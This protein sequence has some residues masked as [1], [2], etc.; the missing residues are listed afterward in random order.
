MLQSAG[1]HAT[2]DTNGTTAAA[3]PSYSFA[4]NSSLGKSLYVPLVASALYWKI[5]GAAFMKSFGAVPFVIMITWKSL[6]FSHSNFQGVQ[7]QLSWR[8]VMFY[9]PFISWFHLPIVAY[10]YIMLTLTFMTYIYISSI[11]YILSTYKITVIWCN[12]CTASTVALLIYFENGRRGRWEGIWNGRGREAMCRPMWSRKVG[13]SSQKVG[14]NRWSSQ[15]WLL[16]DRSVICAVTPGPYVT[17]SLMPLCP[18]C[19]GEGNKQSALSTPKSA[20][21]AVTF[22]LPAI[23]SQPDGTGAAG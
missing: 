17:V 9:L 10:N 3:L 7:S 16:Y 21:T 14:L 11:S 1:P 22:S 18:C 2:P 23:P 4:V 19:A 12:F 8:Y 5:T 6:V 20:A 13:N 15:W